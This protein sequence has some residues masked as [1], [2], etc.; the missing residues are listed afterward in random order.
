MSETLY[1]LSKRFDDVQPPKEVAPLM[2]EENR[3]LIIDAYKT[4]MEPKIKEFC[5][6]IKEFTSEIEIIGEISFI[7]NILFVLFRLHEPITE[8]VKLVEYLRT[9]GYIIAEDGPIYLIE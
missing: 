8:H 7:G 6:E 5:E 3:K 9:K 1:M 2:R 4:Q